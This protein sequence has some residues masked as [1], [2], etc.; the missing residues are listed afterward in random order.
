MEEG[1]VGLVA[2]LPFIGYTIGRGGAPAQ[3]RMLAQRDQQE[4]PEEVQPDPIDSAREAGLRYVNDDEP[5]ISRRGAGKGFYYIGPDE[6]KITDSGTL[7][8]IRSLA[9]PPAWTEVWICPFP[10][11]HLQATGRDVRGRK[12]YRYHPRWGE[13]RDE[14]K[15]ERT[16]AFGMALPALRARIEKDL[17]RWGL[18]REKV[19]AA[20]VRLLE[21]SL[22]RV[23][24]D[25]YQKE[26][27]SF[28]LTTMRAHHANLKGSKLRFEFRGKGGK[29]HRVTLR[30]KRLARVIHQCQEL[31][32]Q[33]LFKYLDGEGKRCSVDSEDVNAYIREA[34]G[35]N[36]SA[37]DFRTWAGTVLA[38]MALREL[39]QVTSEAQA[40]KNVL[41][42]VESV[43]ARLGNTASICR[44]CYIHPGVIDAYMEG[45]L[46]ENL[47]VRASRVIA[48]DLG[49]LPP[50]E[51]AVLVL[52][53]RRLVGDSEKTAAS[54]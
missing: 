10:N 21:L 27:R 2:K 37:K 1:F 31:P 36:F 9:I 14:S 19:I 8:R 39:E 13:I 15:Y 16:I 43:A 35:A 20:V 38:A 24:N 54:R 23:G 45:A 26:N 6:R 53:Q 5:G 40:K 44:K 25:E 52:L 48:R 4:V 50:E 7:R 33:R 49:Q 29:Q 17:S 11:G 18:P 3:I 51:A 41:R 32:G 30:S 34:T 22:I 28:G 42:A 12:Q 46:A 47:K